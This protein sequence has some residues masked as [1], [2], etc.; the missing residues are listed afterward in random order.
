M[1][2]I[3]LVFKLQDMRYQ[4]DVMY[5]SNTALDWVRTKAK[6]NRGRK[7]TGEG[8]CNKLEDNN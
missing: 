1:R 7:V 6:H 5:V 4:V 3:G 8:Y 2:E